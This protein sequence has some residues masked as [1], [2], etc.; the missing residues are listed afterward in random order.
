MLQLYK[1][2]FLP[3]HHVK[4]TEALYSNQ[5]SH[6]IKKSYRTYFKHNHCLHINCLYFFWSMSCVHQGIHK[7]NIFNKHILP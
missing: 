5:A 1:S 7:W 6:E 4:N 2:M 3:L